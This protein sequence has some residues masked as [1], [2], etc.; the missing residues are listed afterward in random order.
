MRLL[1]LLGTTFNPSP[2]LVC[3]GLSSPPLSI[4]QYVWLGDG[5]FGKGCA[6]KAAV[7]FSY[8]NLWKVDSE[9]WTCQRGWHFSVFVEFGLHSRARDGQKI[10]RTSWDKTIVE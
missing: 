3:T 5:D 8:D 4:S 2:Y 1:G 9:K 6:D 10:S 7:A